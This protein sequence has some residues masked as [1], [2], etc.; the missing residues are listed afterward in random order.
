MQ[1]LE[2]NSQ[3]EF[4]NFINNTKQMI[5]NSLIKKT[6]LQMWQTTR[7]KELNRKKV[8]RKR[9]RFETDN[10]KLIKKNAK[11]IIIAKLQKRKNDEKKRIDALFMKIWRMKRDNMHTKRITAR[12]VEK[13]RIKQI[14]EMIKNHLFIFVKLLQSILDLEIEWKRIKERYD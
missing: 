11:F 13:T 1:G 6:K 9:L 7:Q 14:K 5:A 4:Q 3:E 10:L 8:F 2:V 12:K